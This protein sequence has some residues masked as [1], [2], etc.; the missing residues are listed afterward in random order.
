ML[1]D[2]FSEARLAAGLSQETVAASTGLSRSVYGRVERAGRPTLSVI[3]TC[4]I[5]TVLGHDVSLRLFP[6]ADPLRDAAQQELI[7]RLA[8][9]TQPPLRLRPEVPLPRIG[10]RPELRAWDAVIEGVG[11]RTTVEVET[12]LADAQAQERRIALKR[13]D[14]PGPGFLLVVADTRGN[15]RVLASHPELWAD[16][17]RLRSR[18]I[19]SAL[20]EGRHPPTGVVLL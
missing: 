5:A 6:T 1:A 2:E 4:Q 9:L 18:A 10:D 15:R 19:V 12:R 3:E 7:A 20:H 13:R 8:A 16:L 14:D 11:E 17:P